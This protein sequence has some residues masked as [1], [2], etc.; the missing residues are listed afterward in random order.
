MRFI[1]QILCVFLFSGLVSAQSTITHT[2]SRAYHF[3]DSK[4][5]LGDNDFEWGSGYSSL[6]PHALQVSGGD[7]YFVTNGSGELRYYLKKQGS[8]SSP[9]EMTQRFL[10][11]QSTLNA[12][13]ITN[14]SNSASTYSIR[15]DDFIR[16][17]AVTGTSITADAVSRTWS[18][19]ADVANSGSGIDLTLEWDDAEQLSGFH[20]PMIHWFNTDTGA[21]E[22]APNGVHGALVENSTNNSLTLINYSGTLSGTQYFSIQSTDSPSSV[23]VT[24]RAFPYGTIEFDLSATDPN[25]ASGLLTFHPELL[26]NQGFFYVEGTKGY[27]ETR[28]VPTGTYSFTYVAVNPDGLQGEATVSVEV[29]PFEA[30]SSPGPNERGIAVDQQIVLSFTVSLA[31]E[32]DPTYVVVQGSQSGLISG[33]WTSISSN[34]YG[35]APSHPYQYG[36]KISVSVKHQLGL[37]RPYVFSFETALS[38][39]SQG[40]FSEPNTIGNMVSLDE[41]K[42]LDIDRNGYLDVLGSG[43]GVNWLQNDGLGQFTSNQIASSSY[44]VS[45]TAPV[46]ADLDGDID[47]LFS[48]LTDHVLNLWANDGNQL[49]YPNNIIASSETDY[50]NVSDFSVGDIDGDGYLDAL[51]TAVTQ[52]VLF[53]LDR[54]NTTNDYEVTPLATGGDEFSLSA[55]GDIDRDYDLD[56]VVYES[57]TNKLIVKKVQ[58]TPPSVSS[59][60]STISIVSN[61]INAPISVREMKLADITGDGYVDL[62]LSGDKIVFFQNFNGSF[63]SAYQVIEPTTSIYP[64]MDLGDVDA[65]GDLDIVALDYQNDLVIQ[66]TNE[67]VS[68]GKTTIYSGIPDP[69]ALAMGDLD[70]DGDLDLVTA[71]DNDPANE[72]Y[73]LENKDLVAPVIVDQIFEVAEGMDAGVAI[74]MVEASDDMGIQSMEIISGNTE[75]FFEINNFGR[76]ALT[77]AGEAVDAPTFDFETLPNEFVLGVAVSDRDNTSTASVTINITNVN[78]APAAQDITLSAPRTGTVSFTLLGT[79]PDGDV[80]R[81]FPRFLPLD[82]SFTVTGTTGYFETRSVPN[83]TYTMTYEVLDPDDLIDDGLITITIAAENPEVDDMAIE[84]TGTGTVSFTLTGVDPDGNDTDLIFQPLELPEL[85]SFSVSGTTGYFETQLVPSGT[86]TM[87]YMAIDLDGNTGTATITAQVLPGEARV[88]QDMLYNTDEDQRISIDLTSLSFDPNG[89]SLTYSILTPPEHGTAVI[90]ATHLLYSGSA[91]ST[92]VDSL[93]FGASNTSGTVSVTVFIRIPPTIPYPPVAQNITAETLGMGTVTFTLSATDPDGDDAALVYQPMILPD[94]GTFTVSGTTGIYETRGVPAGTYTMTYVAIDPGS[95]TGE[96]VIEVTVLA[97][98]PMVMSPIPVNPVEDIPFEFDLNQVAIDPNGGELTFAIAVPPTVGSATLSGS[99]L[100]YLITSGINYQDTFDDTFDY[101][102]TNASGTTTGTIDFWVIFVNEPPV[103]QDITLSA[104]RTGTVS[105]TLLATDPDGDDL[106]YSPRI[107]PTD[108]SFT[109][110]GTTGYFETRSVP[111]GTY[112]MTYEVRDPDDLVDE[113]LITIT[114]A[115]QDPEAASISAEVT[116]TGLVS[117]TLTG[118]DPDG[119][120]AE[121]LYRPMILPSEGSFTVSGTTGYYETR[122]V[123]AGTYTMTYVA[124]DADENTGE[125]Q[126]SIRVIASLPA[127]VDQTLVSGIDLDE[128]LID[129]SDIS[130]D[131]NGGTLTYTIVTEPEQGSAVLS[132]TTVVYTPG[133]GDLS[134]DSFVF[135]ATNSVGTVS[136]TVYIQLRIPQNQPPVAQNISVTAPRTGTVTFTL[137]AIDPE[138]GAVTYNARLLPTDGAFLVSGSTGI[139]ETRSVPV[140][141]YT[142]TYEARDEQGSFG[143]GLITIEVVSYAPVAQNISAQALGTGTVTFTLAATDLDGDVA[144]LVY[145]PMILPLDGSFTVSGTTGIYETRGVPAGTYTMTYVAIDAEGNMGEGQISV[146]VLASAPAFVDQTLVDGIDLDEVLVELTDITTDLNGGTLTYTIVTQ[147]EQGS[148]VLSGTSVVYTPAEGNSSVDSFVFSAANASGTVTA[149]VYIQLRTPENRAPEAQNISVTAVENTPEE[150][151]LSGTDPDGDTLVYSLVVSPTVGT[152]VLSGTTIIYTSTSDTATSDSLVYQVSDGSLTATGT[153]SIVIEGVNDAPV[154]GEV[155]EVSVS[156]DAEVGTVLA[157]FSASD[158]D[159]DTLTYSLVGAGY[160]FAISGNR[161]ILETGLDFEVR[162]Q[163]QLVVGASDGTLST[164]TEVNISVLNVDSPAFDRALTVQLYPSTQTAS[165]QGAQSAKYP[166]RVVKTVDG[167]A[168]ILELVPSHDADLMTIHPVTGQWSFIEPPSY[169]QPLDENFDA[170]YEVVLRMRNADDQSD[171]I[172]VL[173]S[174]V[175]VLLAEGSLDIGIIEVMLVSAQADTDGDGVLDTAD[176]C[177]LTPNADQADSNQNGM[178]DV[179]EDRDGDGLV[180]AVDQCPD[181]TPGAVMD[182]FGC[183]L[184]VLPSSNY[185]VSVTSASCPGEDNGS[186][187]LEILNTDYSYTA[188][189]TGPNGTDEFALNQEMGYVKQITGLTSGT[190]QVCFSVASKSGYSQCYE[191]KVTEPT[192]LNASAVIDYTAKKAVLYVQ[193]ARSYTVDVNGSSFRTES[194]MVEVDLT[195]GS[196]QLRI[197]TDLYCQGEWHQEVFVSEE[198]L[199]YPNPSSGPTQIYVG[200]TD[201]EVEAALFAVSGAY[202]GSWNLTIAPNRVAFIDL[203]A[204]PDGIYVLRIEGLHT[205]QELKV[206]KKQ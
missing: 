164:T 156:E 195:A 22:I 130:T 56:L 1:I 99:V 4:V 12:V 138:G 184:F 123:P 41:I 17:Q 14:Y 108:G 2:G 165:A 27:Y 132:G 51:G 32:P 34:S 67:G 33:T 18:I 7:G 45:S 193:G 183:E 134:V 129:L 49:F 104:P 170:V 148:A 140:G 167:G 77:P 114:I 38:P 153:I 142:M 94:A 23:D 43:V 57:N 146:D 52:G 151:A 136:A 205:R 53:S 83:G 50:H 172:P 102:A 85:G 90:S 97:T 73:W 202:L 106:A 141:T 101:T 25:Y 168:V 116:G 112:T 19:S 152:A 125:G 188:V 143:E 58:I 20:N 161:L 46:D 177:P 166:T 98:P 189:V 191:V 76:I 181:S 159:G 47:F 157:T 44:L 192:P 79:D 196:N 42:L 100:T 176:N 28:N 149:T 91:T 59:N 31:H 179:C 9:H 5:Y 86:Y 120:D 95:L 75:G 74:A 173:I 11:G 107:L 105:F 198:V 154:W 185:Q 158:P 200:G 115:A 62:V 29:I 80:L 190:Y 3:G 103:A 139:Y 122:G 204:Q 21:W 71:L 8:V 162:A 163:Y 197:T 118:I 37:S 92:L 133:T 155:T 93:E 84:A 26:P 174:P 96:G 63:T 36:E 145:Q 65:D 72:V 171:L 55:V 82:G 186:L 131:L 187:S 78:E 124:I 6:Q 40:T 201:T 109:V 89:G 48:N 13:S 144:D 206:I 24:A 121:L 169:T 60:N 128:V 119:N 64:S 150:I 30:T 70:G 117:F 54:S 15:V 10:V 199:V 87:T 178:G 180:D 61:I 160:Q 113:G 137:S 66:Y 127:Y 182:V 135:G 111:N 194:G 69:I 88:V 35:F 175:S 147:P 16:S 39:Y 110:S 81:Y 68:F 126:I 203:S